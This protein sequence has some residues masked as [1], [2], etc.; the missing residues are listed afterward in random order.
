MT[1]SD[2][3]YHGSKRYTGWDLREMPVGYLR[4]TIEHRPNSFTFKQIDHLCEQFGF[5]ADEVKMAATFGRPFRPVDPRQ[6]VKTL[7][8]VLEDW[9]NYLRD[10]GSVDHEAWTGM[11]AIY[12]NLVERLQDAGL[13]SQYQGNS[14][15]NRRSID[16]GGH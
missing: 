1:D 13:L 10:I 6:P 7:P 3:I 11:E 12:N 2:F 4:W 8:D 15:Q 16:L 5:P 9:H 14:F